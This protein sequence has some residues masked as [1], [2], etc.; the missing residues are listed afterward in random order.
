MRLHPLFDD[1]AVCYLRSDVPSIAVVMLLTVSKL[2]PIL[3]TNRMVSQ[4][5]RSRLWCTMFHHSVRQHPRVYEERILRVIE[6]HVGDC[7]D[8]E[9]EL[10]VE[11]PDDCSRHS[12]MC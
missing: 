7:D 5:F 2:M 12:A 3:H 6:E 4:Y 11:A 1:E 9:A 8:I 10:L